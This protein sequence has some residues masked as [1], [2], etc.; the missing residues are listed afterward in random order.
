MFIGHCLNDV[1]VFC[2]KFSVFTGKMYSIFGISEPIGQFIFPPI[3]SVIYQE[4]VESFPG[5]IFLFGEIFY[6]PNVLVFM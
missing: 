6:V 4:T 1:I 3:F 2:Q 5:A